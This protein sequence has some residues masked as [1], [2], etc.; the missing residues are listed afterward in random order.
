MPET[1]YA[2][3]TVNV[4]AEH[5]AVKIFVPDILSHSPLDTTVFTMVEEVE[6]YV[7]SVE[8]GRPLSDKKLEEF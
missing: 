1:S 5:I 8:S 3:E 2:I 7:D 4:R 6:V